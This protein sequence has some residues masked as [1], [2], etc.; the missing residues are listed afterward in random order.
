[1]AIMKYAQVVYSADRDV[2]SIYLE[3]VQQRSQLGAGLQKLIGQDI[4]INPGDT[5]NLVNT[6][7]VLMSKESGTLGY[8]TT[9]ANF[10]QFSNVAPVAITESDSKIAEVRTGIPTAKTDPT[11]TVGDF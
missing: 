1:M 2:G 7:A 3:D 9:G 5:I 6:G 4:I 8:F 11:I 10:P